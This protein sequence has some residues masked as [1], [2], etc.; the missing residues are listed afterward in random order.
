[1]PSFTILRSGCGLYASRKQARVNAESEGDSMSLWIP[2]SSEEAEGE[3]EWEDVS[4]D[5]TVEEP[6]DR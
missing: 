4:D 5:E 6:A 2:R 1:L 3:Q